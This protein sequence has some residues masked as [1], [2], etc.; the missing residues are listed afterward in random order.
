MNVYPFLKNIFLNWWLKTY[1]LTHI[2]VKE[3]KKNP[4]QK[5]FCHPS[6]LKTH[7]LTYIGVQDYDCITSRNRSSHTFGKKIH[8]L[9][10]IEAKEYY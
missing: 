8:G 5:R 4:H 10:E 9:T 7:G 6:D 2:G 1:G 3:Y